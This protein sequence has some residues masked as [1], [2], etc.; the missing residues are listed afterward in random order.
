MATSQSTDLPPVP[1]TLTVDFWAV[2]YT[3][4]P[5]AARDWISHPQRGV[6][7]GALL[8]ELGKASAYNVLHRKNQYKGTALLHQQWFSSTFCTRRKVA[9]CP[10]Y[11]N[12]Q[13]MLEAV[14]F[15]PVY[16]HC[17]VLFGA[18]VLRCHLITFGWIVWQ[19]SIKAFYFCKW[20]LSNFT[21]SKIA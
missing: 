16:R 20:T 12:A 4:T 9:V 10:F 2:V 19:K 7:L 11:L 15:A 17:S 8:W 13:R 21:S 5:K 14:S 1:V 6:W 18:F 3:D